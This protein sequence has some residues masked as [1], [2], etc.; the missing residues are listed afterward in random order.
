MASQ[1]K[2]KWPADLEAAFAHDPAVDV[3]VKAA[4]V[5]LLKAAAEAAYKNPK[6]IPDYTQQWRLIRR[7]FSGTSKVSKKPCVAVLYDLSQMPSAW[8]TK[9][10]ASFMYLKDLTRGLLTRIGIKPNTYFVCGP[11]VIYPV[12]P[13]QTKHADAFVARHAQYIGEAPVFH[14]PLAPK[15]KIWEPGVTAAWKKH[16]GSDLR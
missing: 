2:K 13:S 12:P 4:D 16:T 3:P 10:M 5:K 9:D 15:W 7:V 11:L 14:Q 6:T 8:A 1:F